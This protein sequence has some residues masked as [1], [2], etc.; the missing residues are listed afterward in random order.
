MHDRHSNGEAESS[1]RERRTRP[2]EPGARPSGVP[3]SAEHILHLQRTLGNAAVARAIADARSGGVE[4]V[5]RSA[6]HEVLRSS[7]KP[8]DEPV[9]ADMES[10]LGAD[11]SD[12][13]LHTGPA[14][15]RSAAEIGA[16]AYTSGN[17]IVVGDGG[18]DEHT[19]AHE[20]THVIQQRSGPV[21]GTDNGSG[22]RISDP[23]DRFEREAEQNAKRVM[24]RPHRNRVESKTDS[25]VAEEA[26]QR[27]PASNP[28]PRPEL[29]TNEEWFGTTAQGAVDKEKKFQTHAS[30]IYTDDSGRDVNLLTATNVPG[31]ADEE[32]V[33]A[34]DV[35]ITGL[36][37]NLD[38]FKPGPHRYHKVILSVTKSPCTSE[39]RDGL[40]STS[41]K[42]RG[43]TE[44]IL[45]LATNGIQDGDRVYKFK[46]VLVVKGLYHAKVIGGKRASDKALDALG[47]HPQI[48]VSKDLSRQ[49]I[50]ALN[51]D[52]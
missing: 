41:N 47:A 24:A 44:A 46:I 48:E 32:A 40:P 36:R 3:G 34:E 31:S 2:P 18:A 13:R 5:Q 28:G 49:E 21:A 7:G 39:S 51:Q 50:D 15:Q 6:V 23:S 42:S 10:R 17:N 25:P 20:L 38:K 22:L 19:L 43:C 1:E 4:E 52:V 27:A 35:L 11:F 14:A 26:V 30:L 8:L 29:M 37:N 16:R 45:D 33:H 12:V 9:R